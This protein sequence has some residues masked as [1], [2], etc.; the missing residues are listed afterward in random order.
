MTQDRLSPPRAPTPVEE[1]VEEEEEAEEA[2][3]PPASEPDVSVAGLPAVP[4]TGS[5]HFMQASE[6]EAAPFEDGA[7]WVER[8]D[9]TEHVAEPQPLEQEAP[10]GHT[11]ESDP[12]VMTFNISC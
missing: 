11:E 3:D 4:T 8:S 12:V 2:A 9:A 10:N 5:F 7:E 6:L 1:S